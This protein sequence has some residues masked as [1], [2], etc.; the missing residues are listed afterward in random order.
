MDIK[1]QQIEGK[2]TYD[3]ATISIEELAIRLKHCCS[4]GNIDEAGIPESEIFS[5][6]LLLKKRI[7]SMRVLLDLLDTYRVNT[8]KE[9][10]GE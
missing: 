1:I 10:K 8:I 2:Q 5:W 9:V 3:T 6:N 4:R 7:E